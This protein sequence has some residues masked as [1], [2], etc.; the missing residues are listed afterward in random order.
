MN[1][2]FT[3]APAP[4]A[5]PPP[6][7]P[8]QAAALFKRSQDIGKEYGK[9]EADLE[10]FF[11][12]IF[13]TPAMGGIVLWD[14][15]TEAERRKTL[16]RVQNGYAT[17]PTLP[18]ASNLIEAQAVRDGFRGGANYAYETERFKFRAVWVT[19]ELAKAFV[20]AK[21]AMPVTVGIGAASTSKFRDCAAQT[22]ARIIQELTGVQA[23][24]A[25]L[26]RAFGLPRVALASS[27]SGGYKNAVS[28][29]LNWFEQL[30]IKLAPKPGGFYAGGQQGKYVVFF[31]GGATGGHVVY[32]EVTAKGV[33]LIDNQT[34]QIWTDLVRA[35]NQLGM[36]ATGAHLVQSVA[37]P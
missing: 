17:L 7:L 4:G 8:P 36:K 25:Y 6:P 19:C 16:Q 29:A 27:P 2:L 33:T 22:A 20:L 26:T 13:D 32:G 1:P 37:V 30:G 35:Q 10:T 9:F 28:Y 23:D 34:G 31:E 3:P 11:F 12:Y 18:T 14:R 15:M 21:A 5:N 24:A